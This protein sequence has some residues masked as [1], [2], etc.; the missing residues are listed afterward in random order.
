MLSLSF[1]RAKNIKS[2]VNRAGIEGAFAI[3]EVEI[4]HFI[5]FIVKANELNFGPVSLKSYSPF[6]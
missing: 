1:D 6:T 5:K 4:P 3:S 2:Y